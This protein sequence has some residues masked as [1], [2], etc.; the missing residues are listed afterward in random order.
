MEKS[1]LI[2]S[3]LDHRAAAIDAEQEW[4]ERFYEWEAMYFMRYLAHQI[5]T[6]KT[7]A[8]KNPYRS[9]QYIGYAHAQIETAVAKALNSLFS[10]HP[11]F[12]V[13]PEG[14][15]TFEDANLIKALHAHAFRYD[16]V[17]RKT[18]QALRFFFIYGTV[19]WKHAW[20]EQWLMEGERIPEPEG[21][22]EDGKL[23]WGYRTV[24]RAM[25]VYEGPCSYVVDPYYFHVEPMAES[26]GSARWVQEEFTRSGD[27]LR[28][29]MDQGI[30]DRVDLSKV[31]VHTVNANR[32]DYRNRRREVIGNNEGRQFDAAPDKLV[33]GLYDVIEEWHDNRVITIVG[34]PGG[35]NEILRDRP[36][37]FY[38]GKKPYTSWQ[39]IDIANEPWG[40]PMSRQLE[41][42]Q[43]EVNL[44]RRMRSDA[45][46]GRLRNMWRVSPA[47]KGRIREGD[48][49]HRP[50]GMVYAEK[51]EIEP[52]EKPEMDIFSF[53]EEEILR[54]DGDI[55][56]GINDTARG[57]AAPSMTA[58]VGT[59]NANFATD[60]LSMTLDNIADGFDEMLT[61]RHQLYRQFATSE[62][63]VKVAGPSGTKMVAVPIDR[64]R[65]NYGFH[66]ISGRGLGQR[67][68][69]RTQLL[70]IL[71]IAAQ[72]PL[73]GMRTN[74]DNLLTDIYQTF[75]ALPDPSR[76]LLSGPV[77]SIPQE[78][79]LII[80]M[81]GVP[82]PV[83]I[84]DNHIEHLQVIAEFTQSPQYAALPEAYRQIIERHGK[85]HIPLA[86]NMMA[87]AQGS[88]A[89]G[90]PR[91]PQIEGNLNTEADALKNINSQNAPELRTQ[92]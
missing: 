83:N 76:Y 85:E 57:T 75:D 6:R 50:D 90:S 72:N 56:T 49:I 5:A 18:R 36:N 61:I 79:E 45:L 70:N 26:I 14:G 13:D 82:M 48:L 51:D 10:K 65:G 41:G 47:A 46:L 92:A 4:K 33:S 30:Y 84:N 87:I 53:K 59:I 86:Q 9:T 3:V 91:R 80:M 11:P 29:L 39:Y 89:S 55:V 77:Q 81:T 35:P 69:Q 21:L 8:T 44:I 19:A 68:V 71:T 1:E 32:E 88:G 16:R 2:T 31:G 73:V 15:Y 27:H 62:Q 74:F 64:V 42:V 24:P 28:E 22:D 78:Q 12:E 17:F 25:K 37:P 20:D 63:T 52:L 34:G 38:H 54:M 66:F 43:S 67:E 60:R 7:D 23:I 40:M 58:T